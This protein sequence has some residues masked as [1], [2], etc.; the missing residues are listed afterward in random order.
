[1]NEQKDPEMPLVKAFDKEK[2]LASSGR[3]DSE[4][5][6]STVHL[7]TSEETSSRSLEKY[8]NPWRYC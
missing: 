5:E 2:L 8:E 4:W 7:R 3:N 1:M 6:L